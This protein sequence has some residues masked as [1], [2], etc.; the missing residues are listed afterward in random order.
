MTTRITFLLV[1]LGLFLVNANAQQGAYPNEIE[2][3]QFFKLDKV[4]DLSL[5]VSSREDVMA[6]F[7]QDCLNDCEFNEDWKIEFAY[8][9]SGWST[10]SKENGVTTLYKP[11]LEFVGKLASIV[12]RPRRPVV[13]RESLVFPKGLRC[14][15]ASSTSG[16]LH[17][18]SI[19]CADDRV[20]LYVIHD[21]TDG[22]GKFQKNQLVS[23][24]YA[25]SQERNRSIFALASVTV[26]Q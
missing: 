6:L 1:C 5:L 15:K 9:N 20:L 4:K 11:R 12:F 10:S 18:R 2:G 19:I 7:G 17:Y 14:N 16:D 25:L 13:L 26:A 8:V 24:S 21:E 3:F 22:E 23:I